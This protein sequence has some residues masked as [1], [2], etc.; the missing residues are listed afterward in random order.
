[1]TTAPT[2]KERIAKNETHIQIITEKLD[3]FER[4]IDTI[5]ELYVIER[6]RNLD[7]QK[8]L[9]GIDER[10]KTIETNYGRVQLSGRD[11]AAVYGS[12]LTMLGLV[13]AKVMELFL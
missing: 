1:M 11:K 6:E 5:K 4:Q 7:I 9:D 10:L 13:L 12:F 2:S 3:R 8:K